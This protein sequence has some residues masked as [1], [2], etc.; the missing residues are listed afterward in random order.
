MDENK[1]L[2]IAVSP[3]F[4][5]VPSHIMSSVNIVQQMNELLRTGSQ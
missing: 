1:D 5:I 4:S 3:A 2:L